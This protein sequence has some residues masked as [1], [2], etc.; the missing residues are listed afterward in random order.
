MNKYCKK[1]QFFK[2]INYQCSK[3]LTL[4]DIKK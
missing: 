4:R 1:N 2:T 3:L